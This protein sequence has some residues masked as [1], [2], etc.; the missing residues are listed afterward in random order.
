MAAPTF[1][2]GAWQG[3]GGLTTKGRV[4]I[5]KLGDGYEQRSQMGLVPKDE[6]YRFKRPNDDRTTIDAITAFLDDLGPEVRPFYFTRPF[7]S[8][9]L[10]IQ[11]GEYSI[12]NEKASSADFSVT[13][14][15]WYG[16]EE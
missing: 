5:V 15:R 16:A 3:S 13:F 10:W 14:K 1:T 6:M 12:T 8:S 11:D 2:W 4:R 9:E 7:G